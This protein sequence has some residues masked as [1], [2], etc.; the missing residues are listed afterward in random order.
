MSYNSR[1]NA[2][3]F[4]PGLMAFWS[5]LSVH[6]RSLLAFF[7]GL[8]IALLIWLPLTGDEA[9]FILWGQTP[10]LGYYDHPPA[11]GWVLYLLSGI[12]D[13]LMLYRSF[14]IISSMVIAYTLYKIL[15]LQSNIKPMIAFYVAMAFFV[16]PISLMFVLTANDTLLVLFGVVGFYFYAK[17]LI[18]PTLK[19][20]LLAGIMLGMA[21]LSKYFAAFMLIGLLI[22]SLVYFKRMPWKWLSL[23][24]VIVLLFVAENLYFNATHC[25]NNILFNFFSRTAQPVFEIKNV[26]GYLLMLLALMSPLGVYYLVK[27]L[28]SKDQNRSDLVTLVSD[29]KRVFGVMQP[30]LY[31]GIPLLLILL[32]V[33]LTNTI[34]LHWPLLAITLG[35][36]L[37][38]LLPKQKLITL[39]Y[40]NGYSSI[41]I[42]VVLLVALGFVDQLIKES[43]KHHIA[44]YTQSDKV[45]TYLP[46]SEFFT[47]DYSSQSTLAYHCQ[48]DAIHVFMS[49]SK[50]GREDDKKTNFKA[51]AGQNIKVFVTHKKDIKKMRPFFEALVVETL[52]IS[53]GVRY[54]L[55]TGKN[56]NYAL[57]REK[58]LKTVNKNFYTAPDWFPIFSNRCDFKAKY[59]FTE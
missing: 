42:G 21:F 19:S 57:Y 44:V 30:L 14:A 48:N 9:Y 41:I 13:N 47:L 53:D 54:Y 4:T 8:K 56:F 38:G 37:Y 10:S 55:V 33:S 40:F 50:Y 15:L 16:S 24:I 22:Y 26:V 43:Q 23:I 49:V 18:Q 29:H 39:Y 31:A 27:Q 35:Y 51:M 17:T 20:A 3:D 36:A 1:S 52:N 11:V 2:S 58:I 45:C 32:L 6:Q 46:K 59:D 25:W 12:A 5:I 28:N 7:I 34:A